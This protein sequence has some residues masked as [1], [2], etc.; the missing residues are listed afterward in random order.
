MRTLGLGWPLILIGMAASAQAGE[1]LPESR[2]ADDHPG[3]PHG[4]TEAILS[5]WQARQQRTIAPEQTE[6]VLN[7]WQSKTGRSVEASEEEAIEQDE[8]EPGGPVAEPA[9]KKGF[10]RDPRF[11]GIAAVDLKSDYIS[12]GVVIQDQGA[13]IQNLVSLRYSIFDKVL[14]N[15][16]ESKVNNV[17]GFVSA[18]ADFSTSDNLS[19]PSSSYK[20]FTELDLITGVS[21]TFADRYNLTALATTYNSPAGAFGQGAYLKT[22]FSYND[23]GLLAKNFGIRPQL[24]LLYTIPWD[25]NL[26]LNPDALLVEPG[27]SPS[28][29]FGA[30]SSFP[31]TLSLPMR[32]GLGNKFYDGETYGFFSVGP[33]VTFPINALSDDNV[34]T[35]V[36]LGYTYINLGKT[37]TDFVLNSNNSSNKHL[38]NLGIGVSF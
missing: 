31:V 28:Y 32:V 18:W 21:V 14:D 33:Q 12:Y 5:I 24:T 11:S 4:N 26:G 17:T 3:A 19:S 23:T 9:L 37:T 13:T 34:R 2:S 20:N 30:S 6:E 38:F 16:P 36:T 10:Q 25:S 15:Q 1:V 29:T 7:R 27:I 8:E 22:E 35:F